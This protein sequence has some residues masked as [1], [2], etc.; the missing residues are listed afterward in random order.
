MIDSYH[1][2]FSF[3]NSLQIAG[4][5]YMR[6]TFDLWQLNSIRSIYINIFNTLSQFD[7]NKCTLVVTYTEENAASLWPTTHLSPLQ[8]DFLRQNL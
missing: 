2:S 1:L 5:V 7:F 6:G 4:P 3:L 8:C